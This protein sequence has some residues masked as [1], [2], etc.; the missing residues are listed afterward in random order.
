[1]YHIA[2]F[3]SG[4]GSNADSICSYFQHHPSI[5]I[6]AV[7]SN[8]QDAGVHQVAKKY[9]IPSFYISP[10]I[11]KNPSRLLELISA[12]QI[13]FIILAGYLKQIS[14]ELIAAYPGKIINI[15][16]AL[17]PKFGGKGM[18]GSN[19]HQAVAEAQ[20]TES[21]ISIHLVNEKYDEGKIIFQ[22]KIPID[23]GD[24]PQRIAEKVLELEHRH[25]APVIEKYILE[26]AGNPQSK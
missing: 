9:A 8:K 6:S 24:S 13:D 4:K 1:M 22:A 15:H 16:P 10:E 25:F 7:C 20:E 23:K 21:G 19:V 18:Y 26:F 5:A 12:Q 3:A 17:L 2:I 11:L 14:P